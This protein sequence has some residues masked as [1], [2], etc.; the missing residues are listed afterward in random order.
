VYRVK[1]FWWA[2]CAQVPADVWPV[3]KSTLTAEQLA[4][5]Q[6]MS[7]SDQRHSL[8]VFRSLWAAGQTNQDLLVA[9]L[10][11]DVGKA[12]GQLHLWHRVAI[13]LLRAFWPGLLERLS[14]GEAKGW[15]AGFVIHHRHPEL[16]AMRAQAAGCS[17]L[18]VALIRRHQNPPPA[19]PEPSEEDRWLIILQQADGVN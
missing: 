5:F 9:A 17:S 16:G 1:Q 4:L 7:L 10:L 15:R 6:T 12:G 11:H 13:V 19:N 8:Q 3:V 18:A 2:L 14:R